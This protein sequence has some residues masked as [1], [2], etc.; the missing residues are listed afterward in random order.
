MQVICLGL[1]LT[2]TFEVCF[3]ETTKQANFVKYVQKVNG[4]CK[5]SY[6]KKD[7]SN[8]I[9][10]NNY[11]GNGVYDRAHLVPNAD[12][13]CE[14]NRMCNILPMKKE[15]NRGIWAVMEEEIRNKY[16]GKLIIKGPKYNHRPNI[17][18]I[19][20]DINVPVGFYWLVID[21]DKLIEN[22]FIDQFTN[23]VTK[24]LPYWLV[25]EEINDEDG[26]NDSYMLPDVSLMPHQNEFVNSSL[27]IPVMTIMPMVVLLCVGLSRGIYRCSKKNQK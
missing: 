15:F 3:N 11:T 25:G 6:L 4:G 13:G 22:G 20:N 2:Y 1:L 18:K 9:P 10:S 7:P 16:P 24:E 14:T 27:F 12:Y 21:E 8:A 26:D 5:S 23:V 19:Q 17:I